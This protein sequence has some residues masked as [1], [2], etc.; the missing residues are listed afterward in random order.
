MSPKG[1]SHA[2]TRPVLHCSIGAILAIVLNLV[3]FTAVGYADSLQGTNCHVDGGL[4]GSGGSASGVC[5]GDNIPSP[6]EQ[7]PIEPVADDGF[8]YWWEPECSADVQVEQ[9]CALVATRSCQREP[10]GQFLR[11]VRAPRDN[12]N[13]K[14]Q[15]G[16]ARCVYPGENPGEVIAPQDPVVSLAQFQELPISAGSSTVQPSP[17]T[18]VGAQTNVFAVATEQ[19]LQLTV[20]GRSVR[21]KAIPV[22][23]QWDYGDGN[24]LGPSTLSG[25]SLPPERWGEKTRTSHIYRSTGDVS[26]TLSTFYRGEYSVEDGPWQPIVGRAT[27][28]TAPQT[29]SVWRS[30]TRN[31]ADDCNR[32]P[33]G[34]GCPGVA[35]AP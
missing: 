18:L 25:S 6:Q 5:G 19:I 11:P 1:N 31:Y 16:N 35:P 10:D 24:G 3:A 23:Y 28:V 20:V 26:V 9:E 4:T 13:L 2:S 22:E 15:L 7:Q 32:N 17:H 27:V 34:Q 30:I 12:L 29:I 14:Q 21:V 33:R 8:E